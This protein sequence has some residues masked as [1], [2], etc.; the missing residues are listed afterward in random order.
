MNKA[1]PHVPR[2]WYGG[3]LLFHLPSRSHR[4]FIATTGVAI[5]KRVRSCPVASCV[6]FRSQPQARHPISFR[7]TLR[8][9]VQHCLGR[10]VVVWRL[11]VGPGALLVRIR[12][13][14]LAEVLPFAPA[15]KVD[16][17]LHATPFHHFAREPLKVHRLRG[18][19][20]AG[21]LSSRW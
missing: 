2:P 16:K 12:R 17:R 8:L 4:S 11:V 3:P 5:R 15:I 18:R 19:Q 9:A 1:Y 14:G 20:Y 6:L 21:Y 10:L 7:R 13:L